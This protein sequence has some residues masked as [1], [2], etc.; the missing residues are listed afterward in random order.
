FNGLSNWHRLRHVWYDTLRAS[1]QVVRYHAW[2]SI[3]LAAGP[4]RVLSFSARSKEPKPGSLCL[5]NADPWRTLCSAR[6]LSTG[7][8]ASPKRPIQKGN[9]PSDHPHPTGSRATDRRWFSTQR[10]P[11]KTLY[12]TRVPNAE[13]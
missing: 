1:L 12:A 6:R 8:G 11:Q 5:N 3:G 9:S 13:L 10:T 7:P 4:G 2:P